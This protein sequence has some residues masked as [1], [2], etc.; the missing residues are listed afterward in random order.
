MARIADRARELRLTIAGLRL[1]TSAVAGAR[2]HAQAG[3][4]RSHCVEIGLRVGYA[5][6]AGT[7]W[8]RLDFNAVCHTEGVQ[9][10]RFRVGLC[11]EI[12]G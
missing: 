3:S 11:F 12:Q 5:L 8:G 1:R 7:N 10:S 4:I 6:L 9:G 2:S